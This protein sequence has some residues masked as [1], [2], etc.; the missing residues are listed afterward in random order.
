MKKYCLMIALLALALISVSPGPVT[1]GVT[2]TSFAV[3]T[4][5]NTGEPGQFW[6]SG[7]GVHLRDVP[8]FGVTPHEL[9][10]IAGVEVDISGLVNFNL[11]EAMLNGTDFGTVIFATSDGSGTWEGSFAGTLSDGLAHNRFVAQ[12]TGSLAGTMIRGAY[13]ESAVD[14]ET[15]LRTGVL[16]GV[17]LAVP[18]Q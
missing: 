1:A 6:V 9:L 2:Q 4:S 11:D 13:V 7:N 17:V 15:G 18:G 5:L 14:P 10:P 8:Y 16:S 12:G 3:D